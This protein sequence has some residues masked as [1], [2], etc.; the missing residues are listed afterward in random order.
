MAYVTREVSVQQ[1][2]LPFSVYILFL[3]Y[4]TLYYMLFLIYSWLCKCLS[5][6]YFHYTVIE[7]MF[8][9]IKV[10]WCLFSLKD[11]WCNWNQIHR[12]FFNCI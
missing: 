4:V 10:L 9:Y 6:L 11:I 3:K 5:L 7:H 12:N 2:V 1:T 8:I